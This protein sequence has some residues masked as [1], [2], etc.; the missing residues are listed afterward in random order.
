M[1]A[2]ARTKDTVVRDI[3]E[4]L[5]APASAP[6]APHRP[7]SSQTGGMTY[8]LTCGSVDDGKSTLI[9]RLLWDAS[10][11]PADQRQMVR[12]AARA[13]GDP[14]HLDYSLLLDG[15]AAEREQGITI[16]IA[17]RY[18][19]TRKHR[20]VLIDSPGHE[21]YTRNM[22]S[23]ASHAD[24][25]VML[26]DARHGLKRQTRRHAAI[27]SLMGVPRVVLAINKMDLAGWSEAR[28]REIERDFKAAAGHLGFVEALAIP[29][30]ARHGDNIAALSGHS[31]WYDGPHLVGHLE[32]I[33]GRH[34]GAD[35]PFRMAVQTVL[36]DGA[37]FR[38]LAGTISSGCVR[39]GDRVIEA[40]TGLSA[41]VVK[42]ATMDGDL[43][44]ATAGK[45]IAIVLDTDL[46][47]SRG[48]VLASPAASPAR[49]SIVEARLVWLADRPFDA[50]RR[51]HLLTATDRVPVAAIEIRASID[52]ETLTFSPAS[53]CST[54][55]I[56]TA[57]IVLE[58]VTGLDRFSQQKETGSFLLVDGLTGATLAAGTVTEAHTAEDERAPIRPS[59]RMAPSVLAGLCSDLTHSEADKR[60]YRRRALE[61][62]RL[63]EAAGIAVTFDE[64]DIN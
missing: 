18:L 15:L 30:S 13:A 42:I 64:A 48:A 40:A 10:E 1:G 17:W 58:R 56:A 11:L 37:D 20:L 14:G 45:A 34:S 62:G 12:R 52:L 38:G 27:L 53:S 26:V 29:V 19:D 8:I 4:C 59:F 2:L 49:A 61:V 16:D 5:H 24:A 9:G 46:D 57:S 54:N 43:D 31:P 63:F 55:G 41:R 23:G 28:F 7:P 32:S 25:A 47:I 60:E 22:A 50:S 6:L 51:M 21:Q 36:R 39:T 44:R 33:P 35:A 3:R